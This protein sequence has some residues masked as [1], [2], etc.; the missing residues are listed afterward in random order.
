MYM[1][2]NIWNAIDYLFIRG[3]HSELQR[4]LEA[5]RKP[6]EIRKEPMRR[7]WEDLKSL[8]ASEISRWSKSE[9]YVR[10]ELPSGGL[11]NVPLSLHDHGDDFLAKFE[12]MGAR[13]RMRRVFLPLYDSRRLYGVADS[14]G[15][16]KAGE[17]FVRVSTAGNFKTVTGPVCVV[18]NPC[19]HPGDLVILNAVPCEALNGLMDVIVFSTEG[20]R[21]AA[22][23]CSGGDL[24]GDTF[25]VIWDRR[26]MSELVECEA[27]D[28]R[29]DVLKAGI[30]ATA[31]RLGIIAQEGRYKE[32]AP[33]NKTN[34]IARLTSK[35][36]NDALIGQVDS[37]F[38]EL[39]KFE[40][41]E[42]SA[43]H[44]LLPPALNSPVTSSPIF[45][46]RCSQQE[47]TTWIST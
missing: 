20:L 38:V 6:P 5:L 37:L 1:T 31:L 11:G 13:D 47:S 26:I 45:S 17:C 24:D 34:L 36:S 14:C 44:P 22:D 30:Q 39:R 23:M 3:R 19:Y 8:Q 42:E 32:P 33:R 10:T 35:T 4:L 7:I 41:Q 25:L 21:P 16:L 27:F 9:S 29:P 18:R 15:L 2:I 43:L 40:F 28:Y 46:T 12:S